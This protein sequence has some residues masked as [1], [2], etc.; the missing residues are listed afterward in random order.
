MNRIVEIDIGGTTYPMCFTLWAYGQ[1]CERYESL[2]KC[3]AE[4]DRLQQVNTIK[5]ID[6]Y[7]WLISVLLEAQWNRE[8]GESDE[9]TKPPDEEKIHALFYA[10]SCPGEFVE[11]QRKVLE[12]ISLGTSRTV[13]VEA[14]KN[15]EAGAEPAPVS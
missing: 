8:R 4:L 10:Q 14:P 11:I 9:R 2:P 15:A 6:A 12:C 7:F 5:M 13:G 1:V 3:L